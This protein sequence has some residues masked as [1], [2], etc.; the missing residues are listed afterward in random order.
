MGV[1][2]MVGMGDHQAYHP[3]RGCTWV[4]GGVVST[5]RRHA[6]GTGHQHGGGTGEGEVPAN[7]DTENPAVM[8]GF[9]GHGGLRLM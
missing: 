2:A 7:E 6:A 4:V 9:L 8:A 5:E 3:G 1:D